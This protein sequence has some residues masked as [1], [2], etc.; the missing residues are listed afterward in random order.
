MT[1]FDTVDLN[2]IKMSICFSKIIKPSR[3]DELQNDG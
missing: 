1:S 2:I 3:R